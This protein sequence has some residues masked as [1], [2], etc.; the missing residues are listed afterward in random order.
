M[1]PA[2]SHMLKERERELYDGL[3]QL[4]KECFISLWWSSSA[5]VNAAIKNG[6]AA[7]WAPEHSGMNISNIGWKIVSSLFNVIGFGIISRLKFISSFSFLP[8][9]FSCCS[10]FR[11]FLNL[12]CKTLIS[13]VCLLCSCPWNLARSSL[14]RLASRYLQML[15]SF[16]C[17]PHEH[18]FNCQH[19]SSGGF[20]C[21]TNKIYLSV[22]ACRWRQELFCQEKWGMWEE[23][24]MEDRTVCPTI[25]AAVLSLNNVAH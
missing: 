1:G 3:C 25:P 4:W 23:T 17:V 24:L 5:P 12:G 14:G 7:L 6:A 18:S 16:V 10:F 11:L 13:E 19:I 9:L 20:T 15:C 22:Q 2:S 8:S 21:L